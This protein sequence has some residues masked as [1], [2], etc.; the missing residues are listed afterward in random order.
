MGARWAVME[1][2]EIP[3]FDDPNINYLVRYR[4]VSTPL[5]AIYLHRLGAPDSRP[6]LHDHPWSFV[7]IVLRGG[8]D[9]VRLDRRTMTRTARR[10]RRLNLI[11]RDDAHFIE[12]LHRTPTWTLLLVGRRRRTWGYWRESG[13]SWVWTEFDRD[14]HAY[15]FDTAMAKRKLNEATP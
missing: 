12:R 15:E 2:L 13:D 4:L 8:Y 10:V 1:R 9:E 3:D 6:T 7:S 11:R 5:F 14:V